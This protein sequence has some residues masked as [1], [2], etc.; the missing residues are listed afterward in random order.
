MITFTCIDCDIEVIDVVG[1]APPDPVVCM[2][3]M[4]I[5]R[6]APEDREVLKQI[7]KK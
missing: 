2:E 4:V 5:R 7:F 3:C 6:A 1:T